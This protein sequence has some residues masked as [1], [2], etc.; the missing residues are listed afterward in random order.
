MVAGVVRDLTTYEYLPLTGDLGSVTDPLGNEFTIDYNLRGMVESVTRP[1]GIFETSLY[2]ELGRL[3]SNR[4]TST[5]SPS[6]R[7][8]RAKYAVRR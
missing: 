5:S 3:R 7:S 4:V 6:T 1:G 2:D 8:I